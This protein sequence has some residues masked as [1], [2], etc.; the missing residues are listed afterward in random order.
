[1]A[2][3]HTEGIVLK[4]IREEARAP[5]L[6]LENVD[7]DRILGFRLL[8]RIARLRELLE[9]LESGFNFRQQLA[10]IGEYRGYLLPNAEP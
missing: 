5:V 1:M 10:R 7:P 4:D 9:L 8:F 6:D 2:Q 3:L